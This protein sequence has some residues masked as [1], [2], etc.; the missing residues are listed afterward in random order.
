MQVTHKEGHDQGQG[1]TGT[2]GARGTVVIFERV[3]SRALSTDGRG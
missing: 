2:R 1:L 3:T